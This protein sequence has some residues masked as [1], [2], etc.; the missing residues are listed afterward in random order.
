[1][2]DCLI[3]FGLNIKIYFASMS[4]LFECFANPGLDGPPL[5]VH[6]KVVVSEIIC[7]FPRFALLLI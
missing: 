3:A 6:Q 1:M 4:K 7:I 5:I 2:Y